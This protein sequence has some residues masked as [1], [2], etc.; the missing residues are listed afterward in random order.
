MNKKYFLLTLLIIFCISLYAQNKDSSTSDEALIQ[1]SP[2]VQVAMSTPDYMVTAGDVYSLSFV[3][4]STALSYTIPVDPTYRIRVANLAILD[5]SG[6]SYMTLRK[7][8]EEIVTKN[9][10]MSGVQFVLLNPATF[11]VIVKGE[12]KNTAEKKAWPL[13]RLSSVIGDCLTDF[14]STRDIEITSLNGKKQKYD[15]FKANRFGDLSQNPYL[16]PGDIITINRV[17]RKVTISGSVE[18]P[19]TYELLDGENIQKLINLYGGGL[20]ALADTS[21]MRVIH[22]TDPEN[23]TGKEIYLNQKNIDEDFKLL[24]KDNLII[25]SYSSLKPVVFLEGAIYATT[26][27]KLDTSNKIA[28]V[29]TPGENYATLIRDNREK[30]SATSDTEKAYIIRGSDT[31]P[32]NINEI[33]YDATSRN[34]EAVKP[35]DTLMIPFKQFFV[36]V[37]GA[38]QNPS[39][40]PYI[41]DRTWDYYVGLAGGFVK[42]QN[43]R[44]SIE[45][46]DIHGNKLSKNDVITPE[47]TITA[48]TN[49]FFY[50]FNQY[51]PLITTLLS[52]ATTSISLYLLMQ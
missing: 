5:A 7:Q 51:A 47:T 26:E 19:G 17:S 27:A 38:V 1:V 23:L 28:I 21:R 31:I 46:V 41:P 48:K 39:R 40:Y 15:L 14:S 49:S 12:V 36:S 45:I 3:A 22:V 2:E 10:P 43:S 50:Y 8:V 6:K 25:P 18:R 32:I 52:V 37:S 34:D 4:G 16:R 13:T 20:T 29:Y 42:T 44:S 11:N 9:Y 24:N 33:L 30:F 35:N